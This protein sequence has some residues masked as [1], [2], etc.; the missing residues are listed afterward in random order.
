MG[1]MYKRPQAPHLLFLGAYDPEYARNLIIRKGWRKLG[2]ALSECRVGL[3]RKVY[4]RYPALLYRFLRC[5]K[6]GDVIFVPDFR[7]KDVPLAWAIARLSRK[8]IIF[9]PLV[10]RYETK[11]LDRGDAGKDSAQAWHNR[12]LDRI[13][14]NLPDLILADTA[15]H[16][17]Y[18]HESFAV[19]RERIGVVPVGFDEDTFRAVPPRGENGMLEV[20]FYGSFLPLHGVD[21]IIR[22]AAVLSDEPVRFRIVGGGQ[23]HEGMRRMAESLRLENVEFLPG[24]RFEDLPL[25]ISEAD[26]ALGIFG[27]TSKTS[28]VVPNK[29]YQALAVGRAVVT[30]ATPAI[31]EFFRKGEHLLTVPQ[32]DP[33][34]LAETLKALG[35]DRELRLR[36]S[37]AGG[38]YVRSEF[39]STR[40]AERLLHVI[41]EYEF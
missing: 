29:V 19:G 1:E 36:L 5:E 16:A 12:N 11:V 22:A 37:E 6:K 2:F 10:S 31:D 17:D 24:V 32:G 4:T 30:A 9:D 8:K 40:I 21:T 15:C 33:R 26:V 39:N 14:F 3:K 35:S 20:L 38:S 41:R 13:S 18:Y 7:H 28:M 25:L 27:T 34:A 23:T